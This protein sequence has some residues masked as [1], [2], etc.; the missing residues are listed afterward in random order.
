MA[1]SSSN[2][3]YGSLRNLRPNIGVPFRLAVYAV[4]A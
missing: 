4:S 3:V 1:V 2:R